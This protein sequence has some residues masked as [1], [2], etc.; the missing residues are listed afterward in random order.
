MNERAAFLLYDDHTFGIYLYT[1]TGYNNEDSQVF[2]FNMQ[3]SGVEHRL[4]RVLLHCLSYGNIIE[5]YEKRSEIC[6]CTNM[7][8]LS[9]VRIIEYIARI[10]VRDNVC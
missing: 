4:S 1:L 3:F 5:T 10:Y 9:T 2:C 6:R 7:K 8:E